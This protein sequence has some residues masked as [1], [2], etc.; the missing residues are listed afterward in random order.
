MMKTYVGATLRGAAILLV[1]VP[2]GACA[3]P[4]A[5]ADGNAGTGRARTASVTLQAYT[6]RQE[7]KLLA[8][9]A[10]GDGKISQAEFLASA[11]PG[12]RDPAR[13]F[14]KLDA[15]GDGMLD[16]GE[17]DTMPARRFKRLDTD[18]DGLLS[19]AERAAGHAKTRQAPA[20]GSNP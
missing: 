7:K 5:Q 18:G 2:V 16:R 8:A 17:I 19:P 4:A 14:A 10:N 13:R 3:R 12:E 6:A 1:L 11:K 9:D 15:N 20:A